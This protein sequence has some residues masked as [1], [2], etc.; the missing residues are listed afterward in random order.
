M[1][2]FYFVSTV[3][4]GGCLWLGIRCYRKFK[5]VTRRDE[6]GPWGE[7]WVELLVIVL[8]LDFWYTVI[9]GNYRRSVAEETF[10]ACGQVVQSLGSAIHQY[11]VGHQGR[12]PARLQDLVPGVMP[13]LP[14]CP[15]TLS[16]EDVLRHRLTGHRVTYDEGYAV[17]PARNRFTVWCAGD[18]HR[19][20]GF[21]PDYP[22]FGSAKGLEQ[23]PPA[24]MR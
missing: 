12:Y 16:L 15:G 1:G 13:A 3:I 6:S 22:R 11:A 5:A 21:A 7:A 20:G 8:V 23:G 19:D 2:W 10:K 18:N 24:V 14:P 4:L 17:T 9:W